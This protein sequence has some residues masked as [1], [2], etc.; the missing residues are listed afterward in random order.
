V[1]LTDLHHPPSLFFSAIMK[2]G[3]GK[4]EFEDT[5]PGEGPVA[6]RDHKAI[7]NL[8]IALHRGD[9]IQTLKGHSIDLKRRDAIAGVR[10]GIEGMRVG[11]K[12]RVIVPPQLAYGEKGAPGVGIPPD[13]MLICEIELVELG[14]THPVKPKFKLAQDR[15]AKGITRPQ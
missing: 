2:K 7:V 6:T 8:G 4:V 1:P 13:A 15:K 3:R 9:V 5:S 14:P 11:G 10:Y 12:R